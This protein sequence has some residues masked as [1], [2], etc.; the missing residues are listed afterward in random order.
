MMD[1]IS[2]ITQQ[3]GMQRIAAAAAQ[4]QGDHAVRVVIEEIGEFLARKHDR[5]SCNTR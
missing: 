4:D 2:L 1:L 3:D 5:A